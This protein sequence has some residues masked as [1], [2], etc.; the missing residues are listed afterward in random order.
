MLKANLRKRV[1]F[2]GGANIA[3][4]GSNFHSVHMLNKYFSF[5]LTIKL[6]THEILPVITNVFVNFLSFG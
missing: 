6:I 1:L 3:G 4:S 2:F 5:S